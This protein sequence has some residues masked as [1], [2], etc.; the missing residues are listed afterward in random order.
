[1]YLNI[2]KVKILHK[3]NLMSTIQDY[4]VLLFPY[5]IH[6][7][8]LPRESTR[9]WVLGNQETGEPLTEMVIDFKYIK[10]RVHIKWGV[11]ERM[12]SM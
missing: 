6:I 11:N 1:M 9:E 12:Y 3:F 4:R 2:N 10:L 5:V 7:S 8:F